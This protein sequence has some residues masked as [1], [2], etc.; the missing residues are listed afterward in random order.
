[1]VILAETSGCQK[2]DCL[3]NNVSNELQRLQAWTKRF[4]LFWSM[5]IEIKSINQSK[6]FSKQFQN[7]TV[8]L[9]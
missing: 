7:P 3:I 4:V 6:A 1:M 9:K 8:G 2:Q 5:K